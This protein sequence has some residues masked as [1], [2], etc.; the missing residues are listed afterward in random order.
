[1]GPTSACIDGF[2]ASPSSKIGRV[3]FYQWVIDQYWNRKKGSFQ[4]AAAAH[5]RA[6][7]GFLN[8]SS[9]HYSHALANLGNEGVQRGHACVRIQKNSKLKQN[10]YK[11]EAN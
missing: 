10:T 3:N 8:N 6:S 11:N 4:V 7:H 5:S 1:M 2:R 9:I